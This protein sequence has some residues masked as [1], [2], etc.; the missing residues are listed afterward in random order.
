VHQDEECKKAVEYIL[1]RK[2][3]HNV[4]GKLTLP[5]GAEVPWSIRGRNLLE[6]FD[7][8]HK[9]HPGQQAGKG[10]LE[11]L[12][13]AQRPVPQDTT[14]ASPRV[15]AATSL[16]TETV[17]PTLPEVPRQLQHAT[18]LAQPQGIPPTAGKQSTSPRPVAM[19]FS[20]WIGEYTD[21]RQPSWYQHKHFW[22]RRSE[23]RPH[24]QESNFVCH[25]SAR[26]MP[27]K[28]EVR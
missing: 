28:H 24:M 9:Q 15:V 20:R 11:T 2:C 13:R 17:P 5:S 23:H 18:A 10:Y 8:Y 6:Q 4:F 26:D 3:K 14:C 7:K 16:G 1:A 19:S 21:L 22:K 27:E 12:A 25:G